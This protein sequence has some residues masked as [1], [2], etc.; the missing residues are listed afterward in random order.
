MYQMNPSRY[1][2]RR[3]LGLGTVLVLT[4][5]S[6]TAQV[7]A[8]AGVQTPVAESQVLEERSVHHYGWAAPDIALMVEQSSQALVDVLE[9]ADQSLTAP[10]QETV[11]AANNLDYAY[12]IAS[13]I[14]LQ[15]PYVE[16]K[17]RLESAKDK[18]AAGATQDFIQQLAPVYAGIDD[19]IL[20]APELGG[21]VKGGVT[22]AESL[23][24]AGKSGEALKQVDDV[25]DNVVA[26]RIYIPIHYVQDE[27]DIARKAL[28]R[29][30]IA[31]AHRGVEK[32]LGSMIYV[33]TGE[34]SGDRVG[35]VSAKSGHV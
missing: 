5:S 27:L 15:M 18:L 17:D 28:S 11:L 31:A 35:V 29:N 23:A 26:N 20:V 22:K 34:M 13:G 6:G 32:A 10:D 2:I 14:G 33:V 3:H 9:R 16:T 24:K 7:F 4:L 19:L 25:V 8:K 30:D 1:R 12:D 21:Q